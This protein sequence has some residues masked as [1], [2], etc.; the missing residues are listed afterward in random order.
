M[1]LGRRKREVTGAIES[2]AAGSEV[3]RGT[4]LVGGWAL[5][6]GP[7]DEALLIVD[8]GV[9]QPVQTGI[10]RPDLEA[11][12]PGAGRAGLMAEIDLRGVRGS[13]A[14]LRLLVR[15]GGE[16]HEVAE[17]TLAVGEPTAVRPHAVFTIVHDE[18]EF[19]PVFLRHYGRHLDPAD[20]YVLDHDTRDG[21]TS[22]LEGRCNVIGVHRGTVFDHLW[23]KGTV[24]DFQTFLLRSYRTVLFADADEL[25][26]PDPARYADLGDYMDRFRG[27]AASCTGFNLIQ[28]PGEEPIDLGAPLLAQRRSWNP[29]PQYS[30]RLMSRIPLRWSAGFHKEFNAPEVEPDPDLLLVH[31]HRID[32]EM[33]MRRH[34]AATDRPWAEEDRKWNLTWHQRVVD[35]GEF[36]DWF[37]SGEDLEGSA[38]EPVP[39]RFRDQL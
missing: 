5:A 37:Y 22:G 28:Q 8:D 6:D 29:S 21:S 1:A 12:N 17:S 2:P 9:A 15:A 19:L 31:L 16:W 36:R 7:V 3:P 10:E 30:K 26:F 25:I 38:A 23:L 13:T 24:E 39:E 33:C 35:P 18:A 32:Y 14:S 34:R 27:P 4:L 20:I 11:S